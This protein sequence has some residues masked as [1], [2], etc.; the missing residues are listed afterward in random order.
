MAFQEFRN[1][2]ELGRKVAWCCLGICAFLF[3]ICMAT[4]N[5]SGMGGAVSG[6]MIALWVLDS[7]KK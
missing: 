7:E 4:V 3:L 5:F 2:R 6:G 1:E